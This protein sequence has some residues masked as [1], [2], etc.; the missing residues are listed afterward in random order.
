[1]VFFLYFLKKNLDALKKAWND[2]NSPFK[3]TEFD[4]SIFQN[5]SNQ[6]EF[7]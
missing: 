1:M 2:P 3:G 6:N 7:L 5:Q 4:P